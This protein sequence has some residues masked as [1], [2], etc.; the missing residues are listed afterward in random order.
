[1]SEKLSTQKWI[2]NLYNK[3]KD[4]L[5][6]SLTGP[7][8]TCPTTVNNA[9][10]WMMS[11]CLDSSLLKKFD[12]SVPSIE[13]FEK[14]LQYCTMH[15]Y[16]HLMQSMEIIGYN[17]PDENI[18]DIALGYYAAMVEFLHLSPETKEDMSRRLEDK[19]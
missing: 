11:V 3:Q 15:Y 2:S 10:N 13:N 12:L 19:I 6:H 8:T 4:I 18:R 7:P 14:D 9:V 17:H 1:M 16:S 5:G